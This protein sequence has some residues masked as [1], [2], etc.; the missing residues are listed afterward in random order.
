M[1]IF[2][3]ISKLYSHP[4][5]TMNIK[6]KNIFAPLNKFSREKGREISEYVPRVLI[7]N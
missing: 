1:K 4:P 5:K 3:I 7:R 2:K 6:V